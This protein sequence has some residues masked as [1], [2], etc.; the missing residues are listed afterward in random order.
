MQK[1]AMRLRFV[2][3]GW[4]YLCFLTVADWSKQVIEKYRETKQL[5]YMILVR[6]ETALAFN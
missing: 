5:I 1:N 6:T 4:S 3:D 2:N